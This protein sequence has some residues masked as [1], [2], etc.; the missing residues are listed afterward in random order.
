[1]LELERAGG[2]LD[3]HVPTTSQTPVGG[4]FQTTA[5]K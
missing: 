1:V 4:V 5:T 3:V 2:R